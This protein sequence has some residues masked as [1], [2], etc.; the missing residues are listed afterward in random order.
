MMAARG[1]CEPYGINYA[2]KQACKSIM[3]QLHYSFSIL[4]LIIFESRV[5]RLQVNYSGEKP[6]VDTGTGWC[7]L[8]VLVV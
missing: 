3:A 7:V 1:R 4:A 6:C 5:P 2:S 8:E